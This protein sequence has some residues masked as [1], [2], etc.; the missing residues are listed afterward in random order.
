M[1]FV[2]PW[3]GEVMRNRFLYLRPILGY[4]G[5]LFW[6]FGFVLLVPLVVLALYVGSDY[7]EVSP[8]D[9]LVPAALAWLLGFVL[10]KRRGVLEPL[11]ARASMLVC[12]LGWISISALGALPLWLSGHL[13][14]LD[15]YFEAVSGFT[16]TGITMLSGLDEMPRSILFWRAFMQW[17]GGIGILA[18]FLLVALS[19]G[20]AHQLFSAESHKVFSRRPA[21]GLY[22][23]LRILW[24][25]YAA[26]TAFIALLLVLEG[27]SVYDAVAHSFTAL[28]T[29]G[30]SPHDASI[31][32]Y[33]QSGHPHFVAIEYT[34]TFAMLL[35]GISF[36][37]HYRVLTGHIRGLWDN[38]EMKLFWSILAGATVLVAVDHLRRSA[39]GSLGETLRYS[40]FQVVAI[41]T[42]TGF[43]TK[44]IGS[45]YFPA[46]A[47][48]IFLVLMVVGG[49]VGST[50]GGIKLLRV[51]VLFKMVGRQIRRLIH[52]RPATNLVIVDGHIVEGEEMRRIS[53]LFFAWM[54][55]LIMGGAVTALLSEL[56]PLEAAS[57]M[58][59]ALGNIGPC[60]IPAQ[61][62]RLLHPLVKITYIVGMLAGRLE[63]LPILL[64]FTPGA[65][66]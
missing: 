7:G 3:Q 58:F 4:L 44:G 19:G 25:I 20:A 1:R 61:D 62:M 2:G 55:L 49:C 64:L 57:G 32:Y 46:L 36:L 60:Y 30:Y 22:H 27:M 37:V 31:D 35:G 11:D 15:A 12:A 45:S 53:A 47:K 34:L 41:G 16:T 40:L 21:P 6:I 50:A 43:A 63:I 5:A 59:S 8:L 10:W 42:G 56:P 23:T 28:S 54:V 26:F 17:L 29:G 9:Y 52:G 24:S 39:H 65:W 51:G 48:Q 14:Y 18:F 13:G 38:L 66:R 33:R